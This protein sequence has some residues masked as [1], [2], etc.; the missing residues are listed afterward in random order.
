M[1]RNGKL[2]K[3]KFCCQH[4]R[5]GDNRLSRQ[6]TRYYNHHKYN[7]RDRYLLVFT[8]CFLVVRCGEHVIRRRPSQHRDTVFRSTTFHI[9]CTQVV[10][11]R[12]CSVSIVVRDMNGQ[13]CLPPQS[14]STSRFCFPFFRHVSLS[15]KRRR[16]PRVCVCPSF[17]T[18]RGKPTIYSVLRR[19]ATPGPSSPSATSGAKRMKICSMGSQVIYKFMII[20]YMIFV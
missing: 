19:P 7:R 5:S 10:L 13:M 17:V 12:L 11:F 3:S 20:V 4:C 9:V 8:S 6:R 1:R 2:Y 18:V 16:R 15:C 14:S